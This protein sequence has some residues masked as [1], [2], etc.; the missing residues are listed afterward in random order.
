MRKK[1][2]APKSDELTA[3]SIIE[4]VARKMDFGAGVTVDEAIKRLEEFS[5]ELEKL[6][7]ENK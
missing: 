1:D 4:D 6:K 2:V 5:I 3:E 7:N